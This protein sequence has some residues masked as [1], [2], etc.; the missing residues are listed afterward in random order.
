MRTPIA[1][2]LLSGLAT[3]LPARSAELTDVEKKA[4]HANFELALL[5]VKGPFAENYCICDDG[6]KEP[7]AGPDGKTPRAAPCGS[8]GSLFCA[9]FRAPHSVLLAEKGVYLA[10]IFTRDLYNWEGFPNHHDLVRGYILENYFVE[11]HPTHKF[12]QLRAYGGLSGAEVE[13]ADAQLFFE[14]Y[15]GM[16]DFVDFKHYLLAYE[17]QRRFFVRPE[18]AAIQNVRQMSLQIEAANPSFKLL[19]DE[20]HNRISPSLIPKITAFRDGL[21]PE[22]DRSTCDRLIDEIDRLTRIGEADLAP[23]IAALADEALAARLN[24]TLPLP[25]QDSLTAVTSI[26]TMMALGRDAIATK[27][28]RPSDARR[29]IDLEITASAVVHSRTTSMLDQGQPRT[30]REG[31]QLLLALTD[32]TY[33]TGLLSRRERD[34]ASEHLRNI[35]GSSFNRGA[36]YAELQR[37]ERIVEW[38]QNTVRF[39]FAEVM[40]AWTELMPDVAFVGDDILRASPLLVYAQVARRL[41]AHTARDL[42]LENEIF[43]TTTSENV[44]ALNPGIALGELRF[45]PAEGSYSRNNI[46]ALPQ[47]PA[48]LQPVAG[49]VTQGEGNV[50]SHVQLLA[51]SLGIPNIVIDPALMQTLAAYEGKQ[52]FYM[53]TPMGRVFLKE[54]SHMTQRE[55]EIYGEYTRNR[56][57]SAD[58]SFGTGPGRLHIDKGRLN[59]EDRQPVDLLDIRRKD[60]GIRTGPKAAFLGELKAMFPPSVS[61]G[62]VLP[63]GIYYEHYQRAKVSLPENLRAGRMAVPGELLSAFVE[64]TYGEFFGKLL[65]SGKSEEELANWIKPRLLIIQESIRRTPISPELREALRTEF[66]RQGFFLDRRESATVGCF[67]RSDTNVEDLESFNGAGLNLTIP[68][69]AEFDKILEGVKEVWAS[70]FTFRSFSWRQ[71]LIDEPLWVLPSIVI[72]ESVPS[73]KSGVLITADVETSDPSKM[74]IATSEGVGGA[75]D[76][77]PAETLL[78]SPNGQELLAQFKS[79]WRRALLPKGGVAVIPSTGNENVLTP[80]ELEQLVAAAQTITA[81]LQPERDAWKRA[82]PWDI[83]YGFVGGKLW[84]FQVR[85]FIGNDAVN[86]IPALAAF[87]H[88]S[89]SAR[90]PISLEEVLQ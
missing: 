29:L 78:W 35:L 14:R 28:V 63:F 21:P 77:S 26:S 68:N 36:F 20:I 17:L 57:R 85:G 70:P 74:T 12:A 75:V 82:R 61:R 60:S 50:V 32:A 41:E 5:K 84:L 83:E 33:G 47:T 6:A 27:S 86:N 56:K 81:T 79:P 1:L 43:E 65:E 64:R 76:G 19:C 87:D 3:A 16:P 8:R 15:L 58:G 62:I 24:A 51:R 7:V 39:S 30:V 2:L 67:V 11:T 53:A 4:L 73:E 54:L 9:A 18:V 38:A 52:V 88:V 55:H 31:L 69:L 37:A 90:Q 71:T 46:V 72:L 80:S 25:G 42:R 40:P 23:Q 48:E 44:R 49:I 89:E 59:L 10:N 66:R 22:V 13:A 34:S 45:A